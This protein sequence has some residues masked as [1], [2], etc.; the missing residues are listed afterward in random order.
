M[1]SCSL[2][3][4]GLPQSLEDES[5]WR[6]EKIIETF[7]IHVKY[8]FRTFGDSVITINDPYVVAIGGYEKCIAPALVSEIT[9]QLI[10]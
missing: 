4:F 3:Y 2:Y 6:S 1:P 7:D 5:D 10:M 9:R 8:C